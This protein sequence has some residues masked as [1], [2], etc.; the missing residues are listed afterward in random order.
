MNRRAIV[1]IF[2]IIAACAS[3]DGYDQRLQPL[4]GHSE[5]DLIQKWGQPQ[6]RDSLPDGMAL[7]SYHTEKVQEIPGN[8]PNRVHFS[9]TTQFKLNASRVVVQYSHEGSGCIAE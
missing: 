8:P 3:A 5:S 7:L 4:L 6:G 2:P 9:C 1:I